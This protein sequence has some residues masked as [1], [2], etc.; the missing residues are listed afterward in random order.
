[1]GPLKYHA[2]RLAVL[3]P[4]SCAMAALLVAFPPESARLVSD[5]GYVLETAA[6][7]VAGFGLLAMLS[8]LFVWPLAGRL[9]ARLNGAP[10]AVGEVVEVLGGKDAGRVAEIYEVWPTR[11]QVRLRLGEERASAVTDVFSEHQVRRGRS[12]PP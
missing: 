8:A 7:V 11:G 10:F 9:V 6:W 3:V 5:V 12:A 4:P 2:F 1:M